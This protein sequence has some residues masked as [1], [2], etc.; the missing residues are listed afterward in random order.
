MEGRPLPPVIQI[1]PK[2][3]TNQKPNTT[4]NSAWSKKKVCDCLLSRGFK[5]KLMLFLILYIKGTDL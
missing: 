5:H 1:H 3:S 2:A 4:Q